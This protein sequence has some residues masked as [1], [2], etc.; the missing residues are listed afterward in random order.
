MEYVCVE[1]KFRDALHLVI[2]MACHLEQ[3]EQLLPRISAVY[4]SN[5]DIG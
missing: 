3:T 1:L 4:S 2:L 5:V